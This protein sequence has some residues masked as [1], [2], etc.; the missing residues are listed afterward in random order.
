MQISDSKLEDSISNQSNL[1]NKAEP[2]LT[3][4]TIDTDSLDAGTLSQEQA[5]YS[6]VQAHSTPTLVKASSQAVKECDIEQFAHDN[7]NLHAK[8]IFRKKV[9]IYMSSM[10]IKQ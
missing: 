10:R 5:L 1:H 4:L 7:L 3:R 8:G 6:P 2:E 9:S